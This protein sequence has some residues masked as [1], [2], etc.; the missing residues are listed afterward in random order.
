MQSIHRK[1]LNIL[2]NPKHNGKT[3]IRYLQDQLNAINIAPRIFELRNMGY[4]IVTT[5]TICCETGK[6]AGL[7]SLVSGSNYKYERLT[8]YV[9][10]VPH[11][12][13]CIARIRYVKNATS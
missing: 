5:K 11:T 7:Y 10:N 1:L 3:T 2:N 12:I 4:E 13:R 9:G 6:E 8:W